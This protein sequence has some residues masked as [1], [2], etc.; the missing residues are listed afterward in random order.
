MDISYF[1][2]LSLSLV[3]LA[4]QSTLSQSALK[5]GDAERTALGDAQGL[6]AASKS[7]L[8]AMVK[9]Q[10]LG[11]SDVQGILRFEQQAGGVQITGNV[12]GLQPG[13]TQG[14]HIHEIG[15]CQAVD[16]SSAGGHFNP[17]HSAHGGLTSALSHLGDLGNI[18]ADGEGYGELDIFKQRLQLGEG[19][20]SIVGRSVII[21]ADTDDLQTNPSGNS[22]ARVACGIIMIMGTDNP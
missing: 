16:G 4:C 1:R 12:E 9:L 13:K 7:A 11:S 6:S 3:C 21:H 22:G 17:E 8:V 2:S 20:L 15:N 18:K 5:Q 10:P 19:E 14:I